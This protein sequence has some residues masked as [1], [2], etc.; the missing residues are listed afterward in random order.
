MKDVSG[1]S[2]ADVFGGHHLGIPY[3]S[4]SDVFAGHAA[5]ATRKTAIVDLDQNSS[6]T[7]GEA[8]C[9]TLAINTSS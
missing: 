5:R 1:V 8:S 6:I 7:F 3:R 2:M 9:R 4:I